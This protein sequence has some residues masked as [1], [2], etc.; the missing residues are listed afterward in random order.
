MEGI[1][2]LHLLDRNYYNNYGKIVGFLDCFPSKM[3]KAPGFPV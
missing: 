1:F 2:D 3:K